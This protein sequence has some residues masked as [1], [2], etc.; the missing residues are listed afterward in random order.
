M[1]YDPQEQKVIVSTNAKFLEE[2]YMMN[3][4]PKST[5]ILEKLRGEGNESSVPLTEVNKSPVASTL[6]QGEPRRSGR[7]VH[8]PERFI[9]LG[10]VPEDLETDPCNY[11]EAIQDKDDTLWQKAMK[12]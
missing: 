11:N 9:G 3:N 12:T 1:F 5:T 10:E 8:Q 7:V 6:R 2:D 4:K